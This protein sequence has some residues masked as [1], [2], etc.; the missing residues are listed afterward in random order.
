[1]DSVNVGDCA[2]I[3][4]VETSSELK[5]RL[6]DIGLLEGTSIKVLHESPSG[7]PRAYLVRG[8][9]IAIRNKDARCISVKVVEEWE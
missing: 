7:N 1:L 8:A 2:V 5:Q 6:L 4:K 9:V 3:I